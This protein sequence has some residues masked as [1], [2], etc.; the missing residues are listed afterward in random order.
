MRL[1]GFNLNQL[2]CLQAL[3]RERSVTKAAEQVN[4][5][6]SATSAILAQLRDHFGDELLTKSGRG[7]VTTPFADSLLTPLGSLI[8]Q[9]QDFAAKRPDQKPDAVERDLKIACSDA[10]FEMC[11]AE[12]IQSVSAVMPGLR[13]HILPVS[14]DT[15]RLLRDGQL[16]MVISNRS[17]E[18]GNWA[19]QLIFEDKLVC[20]GCRKLG[21]MRG[22]VTSHS[23]VNFEHVVVRYSNSPQTSDFLEL[24]QGSFANQRNTYVWS[25]MF[26][27]RLVCGSKRLAVVPERIARNMARRWDLSIHE[28]PLSNI[29]IPAYAFLHPNRKD[30]FVLNALIRILT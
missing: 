23:I 6:Q 1:S 17:P 10:I 3:L 24:D 22:E 19:T 27:P 9:A 26:V 29:V 18:P 28:Y 11:L 2:V 7:L 21:P 20:V 12:T 5:S 4:L 15:G 25:Y 8:A 13:F 30:D 14:E 16:D